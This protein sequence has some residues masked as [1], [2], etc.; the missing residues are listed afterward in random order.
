MLIAERQG[1]PF[2]FVGNWPCLDFVNTKNWATNEA[3]YERFRTYADFV[4]WNHASGYLS[5]GLTQ[6][7]LD[8]ASLQPD[9]AADLFHQGLSLRE[10][11]YQVFESIATEKP[12]IAVDLTV[13]NNN[14]QQNLAQSSLSPMKKSF[15]W[16]WAGSPLALERVFWP[17]IWSAAELLTSDK[18]ERVGKCAALACG[19]LFLDTSRNGRRRWCEMQHCGNLAK[20][21]RH[22]RRYKA[23]KQS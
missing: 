12:L 4:W 13:L 8:T 7:L 20:A 3:V 6:Q 16:Q 11:I 5:D 21:R 14:I 22:Y 18:L 10:T 23:E 9:K 15:T 17:I 2:K 19:W 1:R